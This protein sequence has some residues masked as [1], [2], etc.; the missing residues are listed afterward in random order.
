MLGPVRVTEQEEVEIRWALGRA[1]LS[2]TEAV[3][4][5][6]RLLAPGDESVWLALVSQAADDA[7]REFGRQAPPSRWVHQAWVDAGRPRDSTVWRAALQ[8]ELQVRRAAG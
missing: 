1:G 2:F 8:Q 6:P 3:R 5:L 4:Q 7:V